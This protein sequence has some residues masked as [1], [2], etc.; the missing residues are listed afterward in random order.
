VYDF[1][2]Q[3]VILQA[4]CGFHTHESD[5]DT[6]ACDDTYKCDNDTL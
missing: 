2:K 3:S 6:Y 1:H 4:E 5:F